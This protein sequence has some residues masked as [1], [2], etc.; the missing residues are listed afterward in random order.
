MPPFSVSEFTTWHQTFEADV[1][2]YAELGISG[3]EVCERKLSSDYQRAREQLQIIAQH[4]LKVTSVQPRCHA[5]FA[6]SMCPDVD[7]P[8]ERAA[9]F[10]STIDLFSEVFPGE[11]IPLVAISGNAPNHN[12]RHAHETA[13]RIYPALADYAADRGLRIMFEPLNPIIMN[14]DAFIVSLDAAMGLIND[15]ARDN[16]GLMLDVWHIWQEPAIYERVAQ[17]DGGRIFGVHVCDWP[18]GEPRHIGDRVLPGDGVIELPRLLKAIEA[19]GYDGAYCLEIFSRD[20]L[21]D[22]LWRQDARNVVKR[23]L[24]GF[25]KS[26]EARKCC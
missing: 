8:D 7:D 23:G 2:L 25:Q 11:N 21:D 6:D 22:S 15:V 20:E 1:A 17:I 16:F 26:W 13:R 4:G 5:L 18:V 19:T 9:I 12:Y 10:R 24:A 14:A 3:I